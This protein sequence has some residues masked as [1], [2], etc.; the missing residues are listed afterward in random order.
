MTAIKSLSVYKLR[1]FLS[2]LGVFIGCSAITI[3]FSLGKGSHL[4]ILYEMERIGASLLWVNTTQ[5]RARFRGFDEK[6]TNNLKKLSLKI[7]DAS[8]ET[9]LNNV[10]ARHYKNE[11]RFTVIG[12]EP[13]YQP[14][15]H[16]ILI[17]GRFVSLYEEKEK[18]RVCVLEDSKMTRKMFGFSN[19]IGKEIEVSK[20]RFRVIGIVE[21]KRGFGESIEGKVYIPYSTF[22]QIIAPFPSRLLY[23]Q[24]LSSSDLQKASLHIKRILGLRYKGISFEVL[25]LT[26]TLRATQ[27]LI[28]IATLVL[29]GIAG[30]SLLVSGVGIANIMF[31]SVMERRFEIGLRKAIG[32]KISDILLQF[33]TEA[34]ILSTSGGFLGCL[35]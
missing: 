25:S 7:K 4:N 2:I 33:L 15:L 1:S 9:S 29:G 24:A 27:R 35:F 28:R 31:T 18:S 34:V 23:V 21:P 26:E 14:I 11:E 16:L 17:K 20:E 5:E 8:L 19:P 6:D 32:A 10:L 3:I 30:I 22:L 13:S 12:V